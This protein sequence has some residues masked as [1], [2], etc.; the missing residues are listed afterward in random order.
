MSTKLQLGLG[1][2][3]PAK[4]DSDWDRYPSIC[5]PFHNHTIFHAKWRADQRLSS[6]TEKKGGDSLSSTRR[7]DS[8][9]KLILTLDDSV[10]WVQAWVVSDFPQALR[11]ANTGMQTPLAMRWKPRYSCQSPNTITRR[12]SSLVPSLIFCLETESTKIA[13][14]SRT[15]RFKF[16]NL[17]ILFPS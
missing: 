10:S 8:L 3:N 11:T 6:A 1:L 4:V 2:W 16:E 7:N 13:R 15:I 5:I 14:Y 12:G 17:L 9:P